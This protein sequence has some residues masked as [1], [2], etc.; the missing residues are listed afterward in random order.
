M[1]FMN[2]ALKTI[3]DA[4]MIIAIGIYVNKFNLIKSLLRTPN[5]DNLVIED[6]CLNSFKIIKPIDKTIATA[7]KNLYKLS[8]ISNKELPVSDDV[9]QFGSLLL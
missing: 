5:I 6:D 8:I 1:T 2:T 3:D 4:I 7:K 9:M